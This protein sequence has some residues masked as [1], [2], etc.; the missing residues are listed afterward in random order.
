MSQDWDSGML[1]LGFSRDFTK[2]I[3]TSVERLYPKSAVL[4][5]DD[6]IGCRNVT[7]YMVCNHVD[8]IGYYACTNAH[9]HTHTHAHAHTHTLEGE[10]APFNKATTCTCSCHLGTSNNG[11]FTWDCLLTVQHPIQ[12][13]QRSVVQVHWLDQNAL[14]TGHCINFHMLH[15]VSYP[16]LGAWDSL[17]WNSDSCL[18]KSC[19]HASMTS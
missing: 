17:S 18:V 10:H 1:H 3:T 6:V 19:P 14:I 13:V 15:S 2:K 8:V 11:G 7:T 12:L 5:T 16:L 4:R 9:T